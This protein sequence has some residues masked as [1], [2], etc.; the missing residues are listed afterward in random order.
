MTDQVMSM[1]K[2]DRDSA[3]GLTV[4]LGIKGIQ[5][6]SKQKKLKNEQGKCLDLPV[7]TYCPVMLIRHK[8]L[9]RTLQVITT[10]RKSSLS[11]KTTG[12]Y[13]SE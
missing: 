12:I 11:V 8:S 2:Y 4:L 1:K 7:T 5:D 3:R 6:D 10:A 9:T 13:L